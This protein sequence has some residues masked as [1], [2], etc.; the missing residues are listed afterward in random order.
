MFGVGWIK[1]LNYMNNLLNS[2]KLMLG[3]IN[4]EYILENTYMLH[5]IH[6]ELI[7]RK[8]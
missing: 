8:Q 6:E 1:F 4:I 5:Y 2:T 7:M 3:I